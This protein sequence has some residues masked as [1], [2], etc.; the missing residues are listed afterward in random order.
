MI[1]VALFLFVPRRS[2]DKIF[3]RF[4]MFF[5]VQILITFNWYCTVKIFLNAFSIIYFEISAKFNFN[6]F[7]VKN[8]DKVITSLSGGFIHKFQTLQKREKNK[9]D[10]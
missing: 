6:I 9:K 7:L 4:F 5:V 8:S 2:Y 1:F 10:K 3:C